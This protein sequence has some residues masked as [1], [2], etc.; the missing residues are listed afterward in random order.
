[1]FTCSCFDM[2]A[3]KCIFELTVRRGI[4]NN[5]VAR[6]DLPGD[7]GQ[8]FRVAQR[9][10]RFNTVA[11]WCAP[12]QVNRARPDRACYAK[13]RYRALLAPNQRSRVQ[14]TDTSHPF[15]KAP[16]RVQAHRTPR[17]EAQ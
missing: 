9:A 7:L 5:G 11:L 13:D 3:G 1:V 14:T 4:R 6:A 17:A 16:A 2:R 8:D 15:T 12:D 10:N